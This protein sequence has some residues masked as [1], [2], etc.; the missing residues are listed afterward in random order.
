MELRADGAVVERELWKEER[1]EKEDTLRREIYASQ[2]TALIH[3][4]QEGT[5]QVFPIIVIFYYFIV[6]GT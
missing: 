5:P 1:L 6:P 4:T 3:A 2:G